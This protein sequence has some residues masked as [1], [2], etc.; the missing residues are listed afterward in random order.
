MNN[1]AEITSIKL[2]AIPILIEEWKK[3]LDK[4]IERNLLL[5]YVKTFSRPPHLTLK[6][7]DF[8]DYFQNLFFTIK[9]ELKIELTDYRIFYHDYEKYNSKLETSIIHKDINRLSAITIP[10]YASDPVL[11]Y[12]ETEVYDPKIRKKVTRK[13]N[14]IHLYKYDHPTLI[15]T[16]TLHSVFLLNEKTPRAIIQVNLYEPFNDIFQRNSNKLKLV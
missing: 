7:E 12:D 15:N 9:E 5:H 3:Q 16:D 2:D 1:V 11:F 6:L 4:V 14:Q 10:I 8:T 13:P